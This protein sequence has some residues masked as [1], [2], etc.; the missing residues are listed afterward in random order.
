M[1]PRLWGAKSAD[2]LIREHNIH[3]FYLYQIRHFPVNENLWIVS[4]Y[5]FL[6]WLCLRLLTSHSNGKLLLRSMGTPYICS[7]SIR[8]SGAFWPVPPDN[9]KHAEPCTKHS[10]NGPIFIS[11]K[12]PEFFKMSPL[13]GAEKHHNF[14]VTLC[15]HFVT[16]NANFA[17][18]KSE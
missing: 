18:I 15:L 16:T 1:I 8:S 10:Q 13:S 2:T 6:M 7:E 5:L 11:F 17:Y 12:M 3:R 4:G 14:Q 9:Q